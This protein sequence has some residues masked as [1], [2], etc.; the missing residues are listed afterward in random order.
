MG[1]EGILLSIITNA[2]R[3]VAFK[4][5]IDVFVDR[6][7][8][9]WKYHNILYFVFWAMT[10]IVYHLF[11]LPPLNI[12]CNIL[13]LILILFPYK[14]K[15]SRKLIIIFLLYGINALVD[16]VVVFSFSNYQ[17]GTP[18]QPLQEYITSLV[19]FF[20]AMIIERT[21]VMEEDSI[22]PYTYR[23]FLGIVPVISM[24]I[25]FYIGK[26]GFYYR[27][28]ILFIATG[29]LVINILNIYIYQSFIKFYSAYIDKKMQEQ[30]IQ[31]Y[32]QQ[33]DVIKE[34]QK[35]EKSL[36]HDMKH[37]LIELKT[38]L[39]DEKI[40]EAQKYVRDMEQFMIGNQ[41]S[42]STGNQEIDGILG[43]MLQ[44]ANRTLKE[45]K[46]QINIPEGMFHGNFKICTILGNLLDNAI[47]EAQKTE[48]K[49]LYIEVYTKEGILFIFIENS[50]LGNVIKIK[51]EFRS[52]QKEG[53]NHGLGLQ[54]VKKIIHMCGGEMNISFT[55][56]LFKVEVLLYIR[57]LK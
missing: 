32:V 17:Y 18:V 46:V 26:L 6:Q 38:L 57:A 1:I 3:I 31:V 52:I 54:N 43:Y 55:K 56:D 30:M 21:L 29:L 23:I 27:G 4:K 20:I 12:L 5:M 53:Q 44:N 2:I 48:R 35:R 47:R 7:N 41:S 9:H 40:F 22:L 39:K 14:I 28:I 51:D 10:S 50:Y 24:G 8:C 36:W 25:I 13:G 19:M 11:Y 37:H 34:T 16:S 33:L 42:V 49:Y 15:I 45:V